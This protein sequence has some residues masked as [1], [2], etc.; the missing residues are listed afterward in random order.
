VGCSTEV[1]LRRSVTGVREFETPFGIMSLN[2]RSFARAAAIGDI[3]HVGESVDLDDD[4]FDLRDT[5]VTLSTSKGPSSSLT[6]TSTLLV[7][8]DA[9][10]SDEPNDQLRRDDA[11]M[12]TVTRT[13]YKY[14]APSTAGNHADIH[15]PIRP[16]SS[17]MSSSPSSTRRSLA[18]SCET[19]VRPCT[20][21]LRCV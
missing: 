20:N 11:T 9:L 17:S 10:V 21:V 13:A 8:F 14:V 6:L 4:L 12:A 1:C 7:F 2:L 15:D 16:P 5:P 19:A 18:I 3:G